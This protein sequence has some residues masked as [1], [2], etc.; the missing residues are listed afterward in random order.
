MEQQSLE[1]IVKFLKDN[2]E[3]YP[4]S[5][6]GQGYR[7]S[8]I[9]TDGTLIPCVMFRK[10][11]TIVELAIRRFK[12]EQGFNSFFSKS[13]RQDYA[14]IVKSFV[15]SRNCIN[16]FDIAKVDKS[17][18]AFPLN[19]LTKIEGETTMS[20]T[21]FVL[22]MKDGQCFGF[23]TQYLNEFFRMPDNYTIDDITEVI[24]HS[25]IS[26]TGQVCSHEVPFFEWPTDYDNDIVYRERPYFNC[27]IDDL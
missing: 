19:I 10:T 16:Y 1:E 13:S 6:Y 4:D 18:N 2:I 5:L 20:W 11:S 27:F 22:K 26:K 15:T 25:F 14:E 8:V 12:E 21:G 9:L 24:N 7:A 17:K 23:G 3:P